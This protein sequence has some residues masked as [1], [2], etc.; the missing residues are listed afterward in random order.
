[1]S[2]NN[3]RKGRASLPGH[4]YLITT[5][6]EDRL[7]LFNDLFIGRIAV[8]AMRQ[9]DREGLCRTLAFVVMPDHVHWLLELGRSHTLSQIVKLFKGRT[10]AAIN[11][12]L[13]RSGSM[14]QS[15]FHDHGVRTDE[16]LVELARYVVMNPLRAGLV[17]RI[18]D[19]ALWDSI[20]VSHPL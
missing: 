9:L 17:T 18:A 1:M 6:I 20:W 3:L 15:S 10:S 12:R 19:Y 14:W 16:S 4:T 2:Y 13:K 11:E 8:N 5:V 7:P